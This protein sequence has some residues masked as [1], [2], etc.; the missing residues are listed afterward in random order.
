[1]RTKTQASSEAHIN[2]QRIKSLDGAI[3][4]NYICEK[5][6]AT[7]TDL[8]M[9]IM[10]PKSTVTARLSTLQKNGLV[11]EYQ[12][13]GKDTVWMYVPEELREH[14]IREWKKKELQR[15]FNAIE[16]LSRMDKKF[17]L[18]SLKKELEDDK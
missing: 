3:I 8:Q 17:I 9:M 14:A 7:T 16:K 12:K 6:L 13:V 18:M 15:A 11:A 1:M 10:K 5:K 4:Y 2:G